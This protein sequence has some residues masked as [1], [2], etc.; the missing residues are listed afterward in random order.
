MAGSTNLLQWN[1]TGANQETDAQYLTDG[2]RTGGAVDPSIWT[3]ALANKV[4]YQISTVTTALGQALAAKGYVISDAALSTLAGQLANIVTQIDLIA[5]LALYA[6]IT[7]PALQGVPL[8][9]TPATADNSTKLATTAFVKGQG[10]LASITNAMVLSALGFTPVQ[11]GGGALQQATKLFL[12]WDNTRVRVTVNAT[13]FG[14]LAFMSDLTPYAPLVNPTF[15]AGVAVT[16]QIVVSGLT[17]MGGGAVTIITAP[18]TDSSTKVPNTFW[19]Q[20]LFQN[21]FL[22]S[23]GYFEWPGGL[24]LNWGFVGGGSLTPGSQVAVTFK[25]AYTAG[26]PFAIAIAPDCT[27]ASNTTA[28]FSACART[29]V[30]FNFQQAPGTQFGS[31]ANHT[32]LAIG[33]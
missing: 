28:W 24:I 26:P 12:G 6:P 10:Y 16:G 5:A 27:S 7:S 17:A 8:A 30:G 19:V 13:D 23:I 1:P 2:Q 18:A 9:P 31:I 33:V 21:A 25:K 4:L 20:S 32:W 3:S 14:E 15:P 22:A 29:A 11:Q